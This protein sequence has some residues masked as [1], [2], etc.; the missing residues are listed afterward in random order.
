MRRTP[1]P[2]GARRASSSAARWR[3]ALS[4]PG[5]S[6]EPG[7]AERVIDET[8]S[9]APTTSGERRTS[10]AKKLSFIE[11]LCEGERGG[12]YRGTPRREGGVGSGGGLVQKIL[13]NIA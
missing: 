2:S 10:P 4:E 12:L 5:K 7:P 8:E 9:E 11:V 13:V 1:V 3:V 6:E